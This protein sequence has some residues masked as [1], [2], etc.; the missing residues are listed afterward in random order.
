MPTIDVT[1]SRELAE[2][3]NVDHQLVLE[4]IDTLMYSYTN[5]NRQV[6]RRMYKGINFAMTEYYLITNRGVQIIKQDI[7]ATGEIE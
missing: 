3:L 1:D 4:A 6:R 7:G 2:E 5:F